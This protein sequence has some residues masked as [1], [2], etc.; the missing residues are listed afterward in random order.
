MHMQYDL[1]CRKY[2]FN[3]LIFLKSIKNKYYVIE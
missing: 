3:I 2:I 1:I